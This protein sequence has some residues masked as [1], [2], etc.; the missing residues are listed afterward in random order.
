[1]KT[2]HALTM[3]APPVS[4]SSAKWTWRIRKHHG[5]QTIH[6]DYCD[7]RAAFSASCDRV[8]REAGSSSNSPSLF[9]SR[10]DYDECGYYS[11][12]WPDTAAAALGRARNDVAFFATIAE[13]EAAEAQAILDHGY[14]QLLADMGGHRGPC[15]VVEASHISIRLTGELIWFDAPTIDHVFTAD[16]VADALGDGYDHPAIAAALNDHL[17]DYQEP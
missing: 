13:G 1:M 2:T 14:D 17:K 3:K 9:T 15:N 5:W 4:G 16:D 7:S 6:S 8:A 11:P 12:A 10:K